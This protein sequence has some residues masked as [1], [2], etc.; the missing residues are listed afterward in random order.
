VHKRFV[1][2]S[3]VLLFLAALLWA[4]T[5]SAQQPGGVFGEYEY[6]HPEFEDVHLSMGDALNGWAAGADVPIAARFGIVARADGSYGEVFCQG[7]VIRPL[8]EAVRPTQYA[9]TAGPR[10]SLVTTPHATVFVDA[11]IGVAHGT[12]R[13]AGIDFLGRVED[14]GLIGSLGGG[15]DVRVSR[16][17]DVRIDVQYRRTTLFDQALS[18][19]QVGAGFVFRPARR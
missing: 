9:V 17:V 19:I 12:A 7:V 8:G 6:A 10:V 16:V 4:S 13:S 1:V 3:G 11:L 15:L 5:A 14:T 18:A 2:M